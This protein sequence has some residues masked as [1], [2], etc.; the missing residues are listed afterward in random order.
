MSLTP[1][2]NSH[3]T[4]KITE[5]TSEVFI[6]CSGFNQRIL[7]ECLAMIV[8]ALADMGGE[9]YSLE[10][11]Y[12]EKNLITPNLIPQ[13]M[14]VDRGYINRLLGL[15][16]K[17]PE[18]KK[19]L[20]RMGYGYEEG[21]ALI[22]PYRTDILHQA[23]FAEDV[24]IAYGYEN[25]PET[26]PNVATVGRESRFELFCTKVRMLLI[27]HGLLEAKGYNLINREAQTKRMCWD[28]AVVTLKSAVS[29]EYDTLRA[30]VIPSL[31][32]T[33]Q[34]NKRHEYPQ[35]LF[36]IGRVFSREKLAEEWREREKEDRTGVKEKVRLAIA[37]CGEDAD[38][39][40]IKQVLDDVL[41]KL[42]MVVR[43]EEA[44]HPSFLPGRVARVFI[45]ADGVAYVGELH[46]QVLENFGLTMPCAAFELDL[47][48]VFERLKI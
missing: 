22:P 36:E 38:Y 8:T 46:P 34:R 14:K 6:E 24:A 37:L 23:D 27:G 45:G 44:E 3:L 40:A 12:P 16:L 35:C 25:I 9:V 21:H 33:L 28:S 20:E 29:A 32:E 18:L 41:A 5:Q 30:W 42:G 43:Y 48:M 26:I 39:T 15:S 47:T 19:L 4:G 31:M 1:I 11:E 13:K 10:L 7:D 17:E 2:I